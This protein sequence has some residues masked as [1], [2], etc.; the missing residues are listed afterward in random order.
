MQFCKGAIQGWAR[1]PCYANQILSSWDVNAPKPILTGTG[2]MELSHPVR[3]SWTEGPQIS[4]AE[5]PEQ[6]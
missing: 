6:D 2:Q 5:I 1:D 4:A 3:V